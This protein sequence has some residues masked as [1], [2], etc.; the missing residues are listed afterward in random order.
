LQQLLDFEDPQI[1]DWLRDLSAPD[2]QE[3]VEL[4]ALI[5]AFNANRGVDG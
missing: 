1:W 2:S 4:I 5:R 3:L